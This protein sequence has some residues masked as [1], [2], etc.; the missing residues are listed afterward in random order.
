ME[1]F[2][3][4][5]FG[6]GIFWLM[7]AAAN[8]G[9]QGFDSN[10]NS[11]SENNFHGTSYDSDGS[12]YDS[13]DFSFS[14]I[15]HEDICPSVNPANGMPM[16]NCSIDVMGNPYGTD[17]SFDNDIGLSNSFDDPFDNSFDS[18]FDSSDDSWT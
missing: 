8:V 14:D 3:L 9:S 18:S 16:A 10:F 12:N 11:E 15:E 17:S 4:I 1:I 7:S 13:N 2:A 5:A 6:A